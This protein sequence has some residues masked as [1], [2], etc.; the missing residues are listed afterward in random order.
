M[1]KQNFNIDSLYEGKYKFLKKNCKSNINLKKKCKK[2]SFRNT[3][4]I[5]YQVLILRLDNSCSVTALSTTA[6]D[7]FVIST[8]LQ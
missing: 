6:D 5:Q 1:Y 2:N 4:L 3:I 8:F 7:Q